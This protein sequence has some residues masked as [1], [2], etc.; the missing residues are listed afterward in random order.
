MNLDS[1][2]KGGRSRDLRQNAVAARGNEY[3]CAPMHARM[4]WMH[5]RATRLLADLNPHSV[6][7]SA[8]LKRST[9]VLARSELIF[10]ARG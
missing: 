3:S 9:A 8:Q 6:H 1:L 2:K 10:G 5:R 7:L 4:F